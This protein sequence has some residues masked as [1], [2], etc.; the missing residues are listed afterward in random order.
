MKEERSVGAN[1]A[2]PLQ[3]VPVGRGVRWVNLLICGSIIAAGV[4]GAAYI[5][6]GAPKAR[7]RPPVKMTPLVSVKA[8]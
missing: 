6:K 4:V 5:N 7:K 1:T 3:A 2:E 8:V